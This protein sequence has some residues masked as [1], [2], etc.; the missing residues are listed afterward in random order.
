MN[1]ETKAQESKK[2]HMIKEMAVPFTPPQ[3]IH[4]NDQAFL[5]MQNK[6]KNGKYISSKSTTSESNQITGN[7]YFESFFFSA[8]LQKHFY[9]L[10]MHHYIY[11]FF[12]N[13]VWV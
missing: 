12:L 4:T 9:P 8:F 13:H 7:L 1:E 5:L 6:C 3:R 2:A 11:F 10:K